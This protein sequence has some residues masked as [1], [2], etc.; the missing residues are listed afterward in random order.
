MQSLPLTQQ[1][2]S[3][4]TGSS[5]QL[6]IPFKGPSAAAV[7][8]IVQQRTGGPRGGGVSAKWV[9]HKNAC[10]I[11]GSSCSPETVKMKNSAFGGGAA[12]SVDSRQNGQCTGDKADSCP[13][14][15]SVEEIVAACAT[16]WLVQTAIMGGTPPRA[17]STACDSAGASAP[18]S[19]SSTASHTAQGRRHKR[20][21]GVMDIG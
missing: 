4:Q 5:Q 19:V 18:N 20:E 17:S 10:R 8:S 3:R 12:R 9:M 6:A 11:V 16:P 2:G 1:H 13:L 7:N 21:R 14:E 15:E